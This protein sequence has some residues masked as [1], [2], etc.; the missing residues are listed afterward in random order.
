MLLMF[1][2]IAKEKKKKKIKLENRKFI[3]IMISI[4]MTRFILSDI[5]SNIHCAF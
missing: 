4:H 5:H 1:F 2:S 3:C